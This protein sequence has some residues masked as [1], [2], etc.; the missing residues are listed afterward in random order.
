MQQWKDVLVAHFENSTKVD[1]DCR[2][3]LYVY[4]CKN[5]LILSLVNVISHIMKYCFKGLFTKKCKVKV[6]SYCY[7]LH[8]VITFD[9]TL[10]DYIMRLF[11]LLKFYT[12]YPQIWSFNFK[13]V[14]PTWYTKTGSLVVFYG[15]FGP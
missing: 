10:I 2:L 5:C 4:V 13:S 14:F 7:H 15:F 9:P 11:I 3:I 6:T 8:D 1:K 12:F